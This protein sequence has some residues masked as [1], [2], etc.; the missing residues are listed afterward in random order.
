MVLKCLFYLPA[1]NMT[2]M[3]ERV[4]QLSNR[5]IQ[6]NIPLVV[7]VATC[8]FLGI[9][10][11][12]FALA[13]FGFKRPR[14]VTDLLISFLATTDLVAC[15]V[16]YDE[17]I[18]VFQSFTFTNLI[19][20]KVIFVVNN[21]VTI[22]SL[23]FLAFIAIDRHRRIC[24][25]LKGQMS[26]RFAK[27]AAATLVIFTFILNFKEVFLAE[28]VT[29]HVAMNDNSSVAIYV[30][31]HSADKEKVAA[32]KASFIITITAY[33]CLFVVIIASYVVIC[34]QI[35]RISLIKRKLK[36]KRF[37]ENAAY[38]YEKKEEKNE[39]VQK[40]SS[41][42]VEKPSESS[43]YTYES[44]D[45]K[46]SDLDQPKVLFKTNEASA[47]TQ[48][49]VVKIESQQKVIQA[50]R[51]VTKMIVVF[52]AVS[53]LSFVPYFVANLAIPR[54]VS[55]E[56]NLS[57]MNKK[58]ARQFYMLN[59]IVNPYIICFFNANFRIFIKSCI[60]KITC[61]RPS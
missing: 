29:K 27:I 24:R 9:L 23:S 58:I 26:E 14:S 8:L 47:S 28:I 10:G 21:W 39:E 43:S 7:V 46:I 56:K 38:V 6:D 54:F 50:E 1:L 33:V 34:R 48:S 5:E 16:Y 2:T 18:I 36:T 17:F 61:R 41:A 52:T 60:A 22:T 19:G 25:P 45:T 20:C 30:C 40:E 44:T 42:N 12:G 59:S 51:K 13:F 4:W 57:N 11:N 3:D 31:S 53:L 32:I 15:A 35:R 55:T 49:V 37:E